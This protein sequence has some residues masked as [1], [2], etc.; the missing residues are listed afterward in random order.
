M[1]QPPLNQDIFIIVQQNTAMSLAPTRALRK[2][3][4]LFYSVTPTVFLSYDSAFN[5]VK[6]ARRR[7]TDIDQQNRGP[8]NIIRVPKED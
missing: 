3:C 6:R 1:R 4:P 8:F 2:A 7:M 5:A